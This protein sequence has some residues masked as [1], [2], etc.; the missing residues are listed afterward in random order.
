M[1]DIYS[2]KQ[3]EQISIMALNKLLMVSSKGRIQSYI[4]DNDKEPMWDGH[5]YIYKESGSE[6]RDD[7]LF[8]IPVQVKSKEVKRFDNKFLSYPIDTVCLKSYFNDNGIIY[9]VVEIKVDDYGREETKVFYK[10]LLPSDIKKILDNTSEN[11][12]SKNVHLNRILT[13]KSNFYDVCFQFNELRKIQSIELINNPMPLEKVQDKEIKIIMPNGFNDLLSGD[14][15]SYCLLDDNMKVPVEFPDK[16]IECTISLKNTIDFNNKSFTNCKKHITNTGEV[17][18]TFGDGIVFKNDKKLT[19]KSSEDNVDERLKTL[20]YILTILINKEK[21]SYPQNEMRLISQLEEEKHLLEDIINVCSRFNINTNMVR[22]KDFNEGDFKVLNLLLNVKMKGTMTGGQIECLIVDFLK[23]KIA[24]YKVTYED[25][26]VFYDFYSNKINLC[27]VGEYE[28]KKVEFSRFALVD[29]RFFICE[30]S[31]IKLIRDSIIPFKEG[32]EEILS[33]YYNQLILALIKAWDISHNKKI[34]D[35][36]EYLME[37]IKGHVGYDIETINKLQIKYRVNN[38][39][40][41]KDKEELYRIKF[42]EEISNDKVCAIC[43]LLEDYEGFE[44]RFEK[45]LKEEQEN[46]QKY[47][48][49]TLYKKN[50]INEA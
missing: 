2:D 1:G 48:I 22:L 26:V 24:L 17:Y 49:Y 32:Y 19:I 10:I 45:L 20:E 50:I 39:L 7:F 27:I 12:I 34:I 23:Y 14:F 38:G 16:F 28:D 6:K 30:N 9:F 25:S 37:L 43:I 15:Y 3:R 8:R 42:K 46:F 35:L 41:H 18:F 44:E 5:I 13:T 11:Q 4:S 33:N 31:N 29:E 21:I 40:S 47:P 36:I